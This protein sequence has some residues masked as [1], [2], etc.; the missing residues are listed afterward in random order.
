MVVEFEEQDWNRP[1]VIGFKHDPKACGFIIKLTRGDG[2]ICDDAMAVQFK[3]YK[4]NGA[5]IYPRASYIAARRVWALEL[6]DPETETDPDGYWLDYTCQHG[7]WTQYPGIYHEADKQKTSDLIRLGYYEDEIPYWHPQA[8]PSSPTPYEYYHDGDEFPGDVIDFEGHDVAR[9]TKRETG[10][11]VIARRYYFKQHKGIVIDRWWIRSSIPY[12]VVRQM[13]TFDF[14]KVIKSSAVYSAYGYDPGVWVDVEWV[15][16]LL[17][18]HAHDMAPNGLT[19]RDEDGNLLL[20]INDFDLP[21]PWPVL[22]V[23]AYGPAVDGR[24]H[25]LA[26]KD[27]CPDGPLVHSTPCGQ[28][29]FG[30]DF[31]Y[32]SDAFEIAVSI[33]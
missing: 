33:L 4:S 25:N 17:S 5:I 21:P 32:V 24:E 26:L 9:I 12:M 14:Y 31:S 19:V 18:E 13:K 16:G 28:W 29:H 3:L 1:K 10:N 7:L 27:N 11:S 23:N 8:M 2:A 15:C 30:F 20:T 6:R 22:A